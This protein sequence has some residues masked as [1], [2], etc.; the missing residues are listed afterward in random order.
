MR[1]IPE[2][3]LI[4]TT[5]YLLGMPDEVVLG[6]MRLL[7]EKVLQD[8]FEATSRDVWELLVALDVTCV[9]F[10]Q[11]GKVSQRIAYVSP[12]HLQREL[13]RRLGD[14]DDLEYV[15][16]RKWYR[17]LN[18]ARMMDLL[19]QRDEDGKVRPK[20]RGYPRKGRR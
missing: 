10:R 12:W 5:D 7:S 3:W 19:R 2:G 20:R 15:E 18:R 17:T 16:A 4:A 11:R 8:L 1:K 13:W 14:G 9:V 6:D